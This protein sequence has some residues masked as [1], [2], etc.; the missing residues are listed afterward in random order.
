MIV[1]CSVVVIGFFF[2]LLFF[3]HNLHLLRVA[4]LFAF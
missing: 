4:F 3:L 1:L 2:F